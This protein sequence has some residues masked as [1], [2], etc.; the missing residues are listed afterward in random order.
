MSTEAKCN[1]QLCNGHIAF[2][3]EMAG[4]TTA[5]PHCGMETKLFIPNVAKVALDKSTPNVSVEIRRAAS[6]LGMASLVLGIIACIFC[7][8]P[9][10]GLFVIPIAV[11]GLVLAIIGFVMAR[12]NKETGIAIPTGGVTE[13][14][15]KG[16]V[17]C[18]K[19]GRSV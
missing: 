15:T 16:F 13:G 10:F 14:V 17:T 3:A 2:P 7:W 1:C 18:S 6:P 9:L 19:G 8:I 12:Q 4:Q 11:I 5:C